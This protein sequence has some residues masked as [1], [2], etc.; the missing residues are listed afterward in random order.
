TGN[1]LEGS[2]RA[3]Q[4]GL[5]PIEGTVWN[6]PAAVRF[7][8][9]NTQVSV[10]LR[11]PHELRYLVLQGDNNDDY[12]V[13]ASEDGQAFHA[14]WTAGVITEG[15]GLRTRFVALR[16]TERARYLRIHGSGGD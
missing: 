8:D 11:A 14:L 10:D 12:V 16:T 13:E 1:G 9:A 4:D 6:A 2:A 3:L 7:H 15:M 5:L